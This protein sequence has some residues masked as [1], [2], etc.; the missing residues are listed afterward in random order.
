MP[1]DGLGLTVAAERLTASNLARNAVEGCRG[2]PA[3]A[4]SLSGDRSASFV[5]CAS[6]APRAKRERAAMK[7]LPKESG[8]DETAVAV[9]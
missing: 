9:I 1:V 3:A 2:D 4:N 7:P 6:R 5:G 8:R